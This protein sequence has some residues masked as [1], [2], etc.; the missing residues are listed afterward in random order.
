MEVIPLVD[1]EDDKVWLR[2]GE[3]CGL[4]V[5]FLVS[6]A[7]LH[8]ACNL[9]IGFFVT[10]TSNLSREN[11][12]VKSYVICLFSPL[13]E[14]EQET[15]GF[16]KLDIFI[17]LQFEWDISVVSDGFSSFIQINRNFIVRI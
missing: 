4:F 1:T 11:Y 3:S 16:V 12:D 5:L 10:S 17:F 9:P 7:S 15:L 13:T 2:S 14:R 8:L 6:S